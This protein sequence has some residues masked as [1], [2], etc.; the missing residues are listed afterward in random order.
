MCPLIL[1]TLTHKRRQHSGAVLA[2]LWQP[3]ATKERSR[4]GPCYAATHSPAYAI[5]FLRL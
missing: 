4:A 3:F 1:G 5:I 2:V